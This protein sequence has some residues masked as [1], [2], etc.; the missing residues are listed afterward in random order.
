ML[1]ANY[2][3]VVSMKV[4]QKSVPSTHYR[5]LLSD[6]ENLEYLGRVNKSAFYR[7]VC[8]VNHYAVDFCK[9]FGWTEERLTYKIVQA[10]VDAGY[11]NFRG[12][13]NTNIRIGSSEMRKAQI[14]VADAFRPMDGSG[15]I[16]NW[17]RLISSL[18]MQ[19]SPGFP[20]TLWEPDKRR[21]TRDHVWRD[22]FHNFVR[23]SVNGER[24]VVLWVNSVKWELKPKNKVLMNKVRTFTAGPIELTLLG[25]M[26]FS[27][28]NEKMISAGG[29]FIVPSGVGYQKFGGGWH[30]LYRYLAYGEVENLGIK[31]KSESWQS[32]TI[33]LDVSTFDRMISDQFMYCVRDLRKSFVHKDV[34]SSVVNNM[35]DAFYDNVVH[36]HVVLD[37][38][39]VLKKNMGNPSGQKNTITDNT[40]CNVLAW[41]VAW[42]SLMPTEYHS[43]HVFAQYVRLVAVGDDSIATVSPQVRDLF[44]PKAIKQVITDKLGWKFKMGGDDFMELD[45]VEFCSM[46]FHKE[47]DGK[48]FPVPETQK[49]ISSLIGKNERESNLLLLLRTLGLRLDSWYNAECRELLDALIEQMLY[50]NAQSRGSMFQ[51]DPSGLSF[52]K[53]IPGNKSRLAIEDLYW[54]RDAI[55]D[56]PYKVL[57]I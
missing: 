14:M 17:E 36:S 39:D 16:E 57:D 8:G 21:L 42:N 5:K 48:I 35:I 27:I 33:S 26:L 31:A 44:N 53:I 41:V 40:L 28:Q 30:R 2:P 51:N 34:Q 55:I 6:A 32:G 43:W 20:W 10:N 23:R 15:I 54:N 38:G 45:V 46:F 49:V 22:Y 9:K 56:L 25:E 12:Y 18:D 50:D 29:S 47:K 1:I 7:E 11:M 52:E 13:N 3:L 4:Y 24:P 37:N 19:T